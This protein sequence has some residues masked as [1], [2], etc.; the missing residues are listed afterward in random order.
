[1][2]NPKHLIGPSRPSG[3]GLAQAGHPVS[4]LC[5]SFSRSSS[6][7]FAVAAIPAARSLAILAMSFTGT[8]LVSGK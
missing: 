1:M 8:G 7:L 5:L 4:Y 3:N 2:Y 6:G